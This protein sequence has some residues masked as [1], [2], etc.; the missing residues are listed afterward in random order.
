[1][2]IKSKRIIQVNFTYEYE[3]SRAAKGYT[4]KLRRKREKRKVGTSKP[5][6]KIL[7]EDEHTNTGQN[8]QNLQERWVDL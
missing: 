7:T 5:E 8:L 4:E 1:M 6:V 2:V 3:C